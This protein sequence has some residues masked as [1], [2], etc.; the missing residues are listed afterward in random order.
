M[1]TAVRDLI[2]EFLDT[3]NDILPAMLA[4]KV[5][6]TWKERD[7]DGFLRYLDDNAVRLIHDEISKRLS[8][9]RHVSRVTARSFARQAASI[10]SGGVY[11]AEQLDSFRGAFSA[12][13]CVNDDFT[14]RRVADMTKAD[15]LYVAKSYEHSGKRD[16]MIGA[17]H[18]A[19]AKQ[20]KEGQT[21]SD[22]M[23]EETYLRLMGELMG[24]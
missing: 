14:Q 18:S 2:D 22:A 12:T 3:D 16:L 1:T 11:D 20:I 4:E 24:S 10:F 7:P 6:A 21:T 23:D 8:R 15:H 19:V 5:V 13:Y 17:F 9:R